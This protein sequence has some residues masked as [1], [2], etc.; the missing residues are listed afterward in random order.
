MRTV[1]TRSKVILVI[2]GLLLALTLATSAEAGTVRGRLVRQGNQYP[3]QGVPVTVFQ[4]PS[5][6]FPSLGRSSFTYSGRDGMYYLYN[7]PPGYYT[8]E[9]WVYP[10]RPPWIYNILV[11]NLP[12]TDIG[13]I[14]IP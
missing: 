4:K 10:N 9:L 12:Y 5:G 1:S 8:L 2:I 7:I 6:P 3:A 11:Y 13:V 14:F